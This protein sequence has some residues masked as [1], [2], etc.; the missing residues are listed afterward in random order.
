MTEVEIR[1]LA[2]M[3]NIKMDAKLI[4]FAVQCYG[5]GYQAGK[6]QQEIVEQM[7]DDKEQ[8]KDK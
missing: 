5:K 1:K 4:N 8:T 3:Y 7:K 2:D 6:E